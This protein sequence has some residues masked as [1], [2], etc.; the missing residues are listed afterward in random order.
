MAS[1]LV[2]NLTFEPRETM[3]IRSDRE[4]HEAAIQESFQ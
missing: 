2:P 1:T 3:P 4:A